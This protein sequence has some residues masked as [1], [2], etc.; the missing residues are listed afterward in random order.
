MQQADA[1][2]RELEWQT[3][4]NRP[5]LH[6]IYDAESVGSIRTGRS[7]CV[8]CGARVSQLWGRQSLLTVELI[9][10]LNLLLWRGP[11]GRRYHLKFDGEKWWYREQEAWRPGFPPDFLGDGI[12][13]PGRQDSSLRL[14]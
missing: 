10:G 11:T 13:R 4:G 8:V 5:C 14:G 6:P 3:R 9:D 2:A 1:Q 7:L 12:Q